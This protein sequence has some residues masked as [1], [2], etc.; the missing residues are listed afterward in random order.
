MI[1]E[2]EISITHGEH[3]TKL[4]KPY[5]VDTFSGDWKTTAIGTC[6]DFNVMTTGQQQSELYHLAVEAINNY[7]LK[8][9]ESCKTLLLY[10]TSGSIQVHL[11]NENYSMETGSLLVIENLNVSSIPINSTE[12]FGLVIVEIN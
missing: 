7:K 3:Y 5:D 4:L 8:L 9:K 1:L 2:G 10:P 11:A 12:A 6:T